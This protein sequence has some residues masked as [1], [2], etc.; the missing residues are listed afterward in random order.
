M[1]RRQRHRLFAAA[2]GAGWLLG[3]VAGAAGAEAPAPQSPSETSQASVAAAV[4]SFTELL[5]A[6]A[7]RSEEATKHEREVIERA[8]TQFTWIVGIVGGILLAGAGLLGWAIK[9]W[10]RASKAD[11]EKEVKRQIRDTVMETIESQLKATQMRLAGIDREAEAFGKRL[12]E[13]R[14][15]VGAAEDRLEEQRD[16]IKDLV[17]LTVGPFPYS[18]LKSIYDKKTGQDSVQEFIL[19]EGASF[20]REMNFLIDSG[21]LENLDL[22][23]FPDNSN[24][25]DKLA[26]SDKGKLYV[27]FREQLGAKLDKGWPA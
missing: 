14:N 5:K 17:A 8:L 10:S 15:R 25:L 21:Y 23:S 16:T 20:K 1:F 7:A 26:V 24:I 12:D 11:I 13:A 18:Y 9:A 19:Q 27:K 6:E 3:S 22:S 2:L 4:Q